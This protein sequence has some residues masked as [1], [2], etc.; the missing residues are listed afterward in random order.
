MGEIQL[1]MKPLRSLGPW[2]VYWKIAYQ[3][4][5]GDLCTLLEP[6]SLYEQ[7]PEVGWFPTSFEGLHASSMVKG[8][9]D[10]ALERFL[11]F[12]SFRDQGRVMVT[13]K[14]KLLQV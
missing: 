10:C 1:A 12:S 9:G 5:M 13:R 7:I 6:I 3:P 2:K 8:P 4:P 11:L 14:D